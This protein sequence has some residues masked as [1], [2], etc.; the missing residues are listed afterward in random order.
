MKILLSID[1]VS[2]G[3]D[4]VPVMDVYQ[5]FGTSSMKDGLLWT[6]NVSYQ[7]VIKRTGAHNTYR[8]I[9]VLLGSFS[10]TVSHFRSYCLTQLTYIKVA[11]RTKAALLVRYPIIQ[12]DF[13]KKL[14]DD[15]L[16]QL[17]WLPSLKLTHRPWKYIGFPNRKV[18]FQ[19][20]I[21]RCFCR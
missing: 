16:R 13:V 8:N 11:H 1:I 9:C 17:A 18:I 2:V 20:S 12:Q 3:T 14:L 10:I 6:F 5:T 19:P 15:I 21:F 7:Y 4:G